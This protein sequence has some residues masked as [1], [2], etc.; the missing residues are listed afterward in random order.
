MNQMPDN[1]IAIHSHTS[2]AHGI[3]GRLSSTMSGNGGYVFMSE[4]AEIIET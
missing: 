1:V 3:N 2:N 4:Q